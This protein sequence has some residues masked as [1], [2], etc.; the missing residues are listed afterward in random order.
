MAKFSSLPVYKSFLKSPEWVLLN[1]MYTT[2]DVNG[3]LNKARQKSIRKKV[4]TWS[5]EYKK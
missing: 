1:S 4:K 3:T 2:N 5:F